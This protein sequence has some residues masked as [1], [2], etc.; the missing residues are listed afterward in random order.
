MSVTSH[1]AIDHAIEA[2]RDGLDNPKIVCQSEYTSLYEHIEAVLDSLRCDEDLAERITLAGLGEHA[3]EALA[4][5]LIRARHADSLGEMTR[6][7]SAVGRDIARPSVTHTSARPNLLERVDEI[8]AATQRLQAQLA[9]ASSH[10]GALALADALQPD[11]E[12]IFGVVGELLTMIDG[13]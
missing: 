4:T 5:Q 7:L 2:I 13:R 9:D 11:V 3:A 1:N 6:L 10:A 12:H 8:L